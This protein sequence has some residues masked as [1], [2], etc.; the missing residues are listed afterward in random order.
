MDLD[1]DIL[2]DVLD[3]LRVG[4]APAYEPAQLLAEIG[5]YLG[6]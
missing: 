1:V 6:G 3:I 5:I 2:Q 4:D